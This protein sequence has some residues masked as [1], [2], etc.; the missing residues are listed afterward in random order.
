MFQGRFPELIRYEWIVQL[1]EFKSEDPA[2]AGAM[3]INW[4]LADVPD[5]TEVTVP[6]ADVP[7]GIGP[8]DHETVWRSTLENLT[9]FS[10]RR[11]AALPP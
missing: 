4:T 5:G 7:G 1:I 6:R 10:E 8:T 11:A 2:F 3:T 9:A